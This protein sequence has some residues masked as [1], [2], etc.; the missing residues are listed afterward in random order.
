MNI[1]WTYI[2][3]PDP[4]TSK[5]PSRLTVETHLAGTIAGI[6]TGTVV[7]NGH[8]NDHRVGLRRQQASRLLHL[9]TWVKHRGEVKATRDQTKPMDNET[10]RNR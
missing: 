2:D 3:Y 4:S 9:A 6:F 1:I 10:I 5:A 7:A 8:M